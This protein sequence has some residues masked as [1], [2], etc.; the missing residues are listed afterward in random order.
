MT[1]LPDRI[2]PLD[3]VAIAISLVL[4]AVIGM[5]LLS[6]GRTA[7]RVRSFSW[8][9][10]TLGA[11]DTAFIMTFSRP[12]DRDSVENNLRIEPQIAGKFS[13]AGLRMAYTL[14]EPA[15]YGTEFKVRLEGA[16]DRFSREAGTG[17]MIRPFASQFQTRDRAFIYI[18]VEGEEAGRLILYNL[19]KLHKEIL[20]PPNLVVMDFHPYPNRDRILFSASD[21]DFPDDSLLNQKL[22]TVTTGIDSQPSD[23]TSRQTTS[24]VG[25][26]ELV[27][28]N[29]DYQN[30]KFDLS[31][32][33]RD[34]V[35]QR[36]SRRNPADFG[37]WVIRQGER[38]QPL[39][40]QPSGDFT[41]TPDSSAIAVNQ[42]QGVAILPLKSGEKSEP[43]PSTKPLNFLPKFGRVLSF[44]RDGRA[45]AM[46][47]FNPNYTRSLFVITNSAEQELLNTTGSI[48]NCEFDPHKT[49]LYCLLSELL[50][51]E[52]YQ[53]L[54]YIAAIDLATGEQTPILALPPNQR[55]IQMSLSPDGLA[56][57]FDQAIVEAGALAKSGVSRIP[58][59]TIGPRN[60]EGLTVNTSRLWLLLLTDLVTADGQP[61]GD[62]AV[63]LP[64]K[65]FR[66]Q[67]LP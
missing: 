55:D 65:G 43:T 22:Y 31:A 23:E 1:H 21:R 61:I 2:K 25:I 14:T 39:E 57:L 9:D 24:A 60:Q 11:E 27:L 47:K 20:T 66:P 62:R 51:G 33:G 58:P 10:K 53:E 41:I 45:A 49:T 6:G 42:G 50:P 8:E 17:E 35:V 64:L 12:M 29:E 28:D 56:L 3:R 16:K 19:T 36:V 52:I 54:P 48:I 37:L 46:V 7:P 63:E 15:P 32:N 34:I 40:S 13:W 30:L 18:G 59:K 26:I 38:P 4:S 44:S 67:W 5:L